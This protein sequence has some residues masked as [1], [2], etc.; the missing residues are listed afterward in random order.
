MWVQKKPRTR[1]CTSG[2]WQVSQFGLRVK[3]V[4]VYFLAL[5]LRPR[6]VSYTQDLYLS[7]VHRGS[8][9]LWWPRRRRRRRVVC[10][11]RVVDASKYWKTVW[12]RGTPSFRLVPRGPLSILACPTFSK[13]RVAIIVLGKNT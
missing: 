9:R 8:G 7:V 4:A 3:T 11:S 10:F 6:G 12:F 1:I 13:L 5:F 2:T